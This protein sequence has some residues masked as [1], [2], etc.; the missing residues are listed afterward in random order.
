MNKNIAIALQEKAQ[1]VAILYSKKDR[2]KNYDQDDFFLEKIT[3][4][5][6]YTAIATYNKTSGKKAIAFFYW[7]SQAEGRWEYF[8]PKESHV[9][10]MRQVEKYLREIEQHNFPINGGTK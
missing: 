8:F 4:L 6:E 10:G 3:P 1:G 5:S 9:H 7:L 2:D